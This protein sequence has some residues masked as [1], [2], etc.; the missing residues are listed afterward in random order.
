MWKFVTAA[1]FTTLALSAP[2]F[3]DTH[4]SYVDDSGNPATQLYVKDGKVHL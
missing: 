1:S 4:V 3:A 2:A